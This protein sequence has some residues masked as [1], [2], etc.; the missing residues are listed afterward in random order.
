MTHVQ[1]QNQTVGSNI[2]GEITMAQLGTTVRQVSRCWESHGLEVTKPML[3]FDC[4]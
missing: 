2:L 1:L 3:T 4:M